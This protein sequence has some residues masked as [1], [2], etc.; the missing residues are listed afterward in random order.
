MKVFQIFAV[1]LPLVCL[2]F[3]GKEIQSRGGRHYFKN[4]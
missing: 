1:I 4:K 2:Y 3:Q